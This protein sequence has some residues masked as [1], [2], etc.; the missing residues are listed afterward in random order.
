MF[1]TQLVDWESIEAE[2]EAEAKTPTPVAA[3]EAPK[4]EA[5]ATEAAPAEA[6]KAEAPKAEPTLQEVLAKVDSLQA[7]LAAQ[8]PAVVT[9]EPVLEE[10]PDALLDTAGFVRWE[11]N[12]VA[13]A[14]KAEADAISRAQAVITSKHSD[15]EA[16]FAS[17]EFKQFHSADPV[18]KQLLSQAQAQKNGD[19]AATVVTLFKASKAAKATE[20][21]AKGRNSEALDEAAAASL[22]GNGETTSNVVTFT[23]AELEA[24]SEEERD[25][26]DPEI[27]LAFIQGRV[28]L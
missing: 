13:L 21:G 4:A 10:A 2:R 3:T 19:L 15:A 27:S 26:R 17:D 5:P 9:P 25:R 11:M 1:E 20:E 8:A 23:R 12:R 14:Q 24:M 16:I 6:P 22:S 28:S 18:A 7:L